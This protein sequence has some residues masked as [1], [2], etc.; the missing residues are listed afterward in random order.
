[1]KMDQ[2]TSAVDMDAAGVWKLE[3]VIPTLVDGEEWTL[4]RKLDNCAAEC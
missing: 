3:Y 4:R 2:Q 1:M